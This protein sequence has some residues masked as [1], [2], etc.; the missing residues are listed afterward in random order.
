MTLDGQARET[1]TV[2]VTR[3]VRLKLQSSARKRARVQQGIDAYQQV[4][5]FMA[6]RL[7]TYPEHAWHQQNTQLYRQSKRGL[8]DDDVRYKTTLAQMAMN[9]VVSSFNS[10]ASN[11]KPGERPRG[12]FG[13]A[14]YL[15][16]RGDDAEV[17]DNDESGYGFKGSFIAYDPVWFRIDAGD[18]QREFL[19]RVCDP[20][21]PAST[22]S[23][24]LHL[25]GET[26]YA[27]Q[28]VKW[29]VERVPPADAPTV[30][31][32]DLNDDPLAVAAAWDR[33][34]EAVSGVEFVSGSEYRH[35]RERAKRRKDQ[36]M[37]D[38]NL[39]AIKDSRRDYW[40]YT[41]HIT[42]VASRRV[43][44]F[45]ADH[46][47]SCIHLEE[48]THLREHVDDPIHDWPYAEIQEKI[49]AKATEEGIGVRFIDPRNTS[50]T[51]RECGRTTPANRDD[52]DFECVQ[53]GY[54]VHAD[55]NAA[56]N[57]AQRAD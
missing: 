56:I 28:T 44:D 50:L 14:Q 36:A 31:G 49:A 1:E 42:N 32:V 22:G 2:T 48:L 54:E 34:S 25:D 57:I 53:C 51:C 16:L 8:P 18:F 37:R 35:H 17:T 33:E 4:C 12:E 15:G 47:P 55:V 46:A 20:E 10:W 24:E 45:A 5:A 3:T 43:V 9:D 26:L 40:R 30:V 7:P 23:A 13:N 11:G 19:E 6:D 41:D 38:G 21:D 27:H 29:P 52:R 39:K